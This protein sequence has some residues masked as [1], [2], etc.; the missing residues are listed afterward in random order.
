VTIR[1][2]PIL[3]TPGPTPIPP[4]VQ[5]AMAVPMPHHRTGAFKR[6]YGAVLEKLQRVYRTEHDVLLFTASGTGAFESVYANLL[7]PG[8]RVLCVS[9]GNFGDR[10]IAMAKVYGAEV[11]E[12]RV[13]AGER[14]DVDEIVA[15][16]EA[17]PGL[18]LV[19]V[20]H[21]ET[22]TGVVADVQAI[23]ERTRGR[24]ALLVVDAVSSLGGAPLETDAWGIDVVVTGSQKGLMC[25]PGLAC[26]SVSPRAWERVERATAPRFYFD[27][28]R[29]RKAQADGPQSP[30]TPAITLV[31]GLD[32]ALD[33]L[34]AG[35]GLEAWWARTEQLGAM[36]RGEVRRMGLELYSPDEPACSLVT[37][38]TTPAD[39]DGDA[40]RRALSDRHGI[41]IAGGQGQLAGKIWRMAQFGAITERDLRAGLT[42]LELELAAAR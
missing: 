15:A 18:A 36:V 1:P 7:S 29:T 21:S 13:P 42:A 5:A 23:A 9:G 40:I 34:L 16:V 17:D 10:W 11:T 32:A 33:M 24:D 6:T 3:L 27:W 28:K 30:Y 12:L 39:V 31:L 22:S 38:I 4:E 2:T 35:D 25:P 20:V 41:V 19:V 37:A 14:P 26:T 8:D